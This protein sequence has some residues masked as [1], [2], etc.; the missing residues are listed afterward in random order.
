MATCPLDARTPSN[1]STCRRYSSVSRAQRSQSWPRRPTTPQGRAR[2]RNL[3][4][5]WAHWRAN[6]HAPPPKDTWSPLS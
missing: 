2:D 3:S 1:K 6:G 5:P 4:V